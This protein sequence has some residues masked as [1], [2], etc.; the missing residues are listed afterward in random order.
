M[1]RDTIKAMEEY[2]VL[3]GVGH[4]FDA[5]PLPLDFVLPG[6]IRKSVG[7]LVAAGSTGK[8]FLA[9]EACM[10]I[11]AGK[12][13]FGLF[14]GGEITA[15]PVAYVALEDPL[16]VFWH[17]IHGI[18]KYL[19]GS[20]SEDDYKRIRGGLNNIHLHSLYGRGYRPMTADD[21]TASAHFAQTVERV[22]AQGARLVVV[23]TYSRFL[24]G[25]SES[26]NAIASTC[27]LYTSDA[28]D[29]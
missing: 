4:F 26:D 15:G 25:H 2:D 22:K 23:D 24:A 6:L 27:L 8:S 28:A 3:E 29:E 20:V 13:I 9:V 17:R 12:D 11:A 10:T 19:K 21:L 16:D 14:G 7:V 1:T 5:D 18:G